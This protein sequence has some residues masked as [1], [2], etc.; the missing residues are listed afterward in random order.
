ML[1]SAVASSKENDDGSTC[2]LYSGD[3]LLLAEVRSFMPKPPQL[4]PWPNYQ[5]VFFTHQRWPEGEIRILQQ[6][7][8]H[9]GHLFSAAAVSSAESPLLVDRYA[10]WAGYTAFHKIC[11]AQTFNDVE[12]ELVPSRDLT[13]M[14]QLLPENTV[15]AVFSRQRITALANQEEDL[16]DFIERSL[17]S[18]AKEGLYLQP[19]PARST[20]GVAAT[21]TPAPGTVLSLSGLSRRLPASAKHYMSDVVLRIAP[22]QERPEFRF[23]L[24]YQT[25]ELLIDEVR[26]GMASELSLA[27]PTATP[28]E[29]WDLID[30]FRE[31]L[32]ISKRIERV[33]SPLQRQPLFEEVRSACNLVV[34]DV[35]EK[36]HES[37]AGSIYRTRNLL[38]HRFA[39]TG[40]LAPDRLETAAD[41]LL[42]LV[43]HV[44]QRYAS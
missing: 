37:C 29:T 28:S 35:G 4:H 33:L 13:T 26:L 17:V 10:S 16:D 20:F 2:C 24:Y 36:A 34:T 8:T 21:C 40:K 15:I 11:R 42:S 30:T 31:N 19:V 6:D 14:D 27:L 38:F 25:L 7:G 3:D 39:D 43:F 32:A 18:F 1:L 12:L 22:Y 9:V 41:A 44:V 23:F 5:V